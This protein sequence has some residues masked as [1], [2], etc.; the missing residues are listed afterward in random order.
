MSLFYCCGLD[1]YN[2]LVLLVDVE[3]KQDNTSESH[4]LLQVS[5]L[6]FRLNILGISLLTVLTHSPL[7]VK[8]GPLDAEEQGSSPTF[9]S[10]T[11]TD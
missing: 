11:C 10:L 3:G 4:L 5:F 6:M 2:S 7:V 1:K 8:A 9:S